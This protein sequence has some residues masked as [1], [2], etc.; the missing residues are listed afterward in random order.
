MHLTIHNAS[1]TPIPKIEGKFVEA[2]TNVS[3]SA[4]TPAISNCATKIAHSSQTL[5]STAHVFI[6]D[7]FGNFHK[8]RALF[9][10]ASQFNF[11]TK[12]FV[13]KWNI[14]KHDAKILV[15]GIGDSSSRIDHC[16]NIKLY[17]K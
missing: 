7:S 9:D 12:E 11:I 3:Q 8:A 16:V 13:D 15:S 14:T 2:N 17:S 5:L 4:I 6:A 10:S 1:R